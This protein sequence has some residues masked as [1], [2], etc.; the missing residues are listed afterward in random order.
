MDFRARFAPSPTGQVHIG[1]IRTA[2][3]NWL[4]TRHCKGTFLLRIEDTDLERSTQE[5]IDKLLECMKWLGL[6]YDEEIMYQTKQSEKHKEAAKKLIET[7]YAYHLNPGE[8]H[9][10]VLFKLPYYCDNMPF[11][12]E[13][14]PAEIELEP[15][16]EVA[17]N[18]AGILFHTLS[19]KGKS[20]ENAASLAGFKNL[21]ITDASGNVL[22]ELND[23][24]IKNL[25]ANPQEKTVVAGA[26]KLNFIRREVFYHDLV[27]G[28]LAKPLDSM[29]DFIIVRSDGS[30]VFH[31]AN[32]YDDMQQRVTHI[33][34]GDDHVENTY[35]H[36]FLFE[37]LGFT[38]PQYAHLPMIVNAAGKPYSKR[39]GDAFVGDFREKGF[40]PQALFNYL[41]LLGWS[42]G[43]DREKMSREELIEAF[44]IERALC[45]PAQFDIKKLTNMNGAYIAEM[46][47]ADFRAQI[48]PFVAKLCPEG[49]GSPILDK[50]ADL[51]HSRTKTFADVAHWNYFFRKADALE[52]DPKGLKKLLS[53][54][55]VRKAVAEFGEKVKTLPAL[56]VPAIDDLIHSIEAGHGIQQ[57]KLKQPLRIASTGSTIGAGICETIELLGAEE[58]AVRIA[59]ALSL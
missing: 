18:Q 12:R 50:V 33:V 9:S 1:N 34:R 7:G 8:E 58:S 52:Y 6:D 24:T 30:P 57:D 55:T 21:K 28:D 29:K 4:A 5:A 59:R 10:P 13:V 19:H 56:T 32:V 15:N 43:D 44:T 45:S 23:E 54:D 27:K 26:A 37:S 42:P 14:G 48:A 39:D 36:L 35:R 38:P 31:L 17:L 51:M 3:F 22:F 25:P 49:V 2:I 47:P 16:S 41:A 53:D 40:L 11:V 20:V 46:D